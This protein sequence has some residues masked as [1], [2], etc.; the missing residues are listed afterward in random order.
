MCSFKRDLA[1]KMYI[2]IIIIIIMLAGHNAVDEMPLFWTRVQS[3]CLVLSQPEDGVRN[4]Q[5][6]LRAFAQ[7]QTAIAIYRLNS[8]IHYNSF[9]LFLVPAN[10]GIEVSCITR[11]SLSVAGLSRSPVSKSAQNCSL[12]S[13]VH[14]VVGVYTFMM[15]MKRLSLTRRQNFI[16]LSFKPMVRLGICLGACVHH[17]SHLISSRL[18][19]S[20]AGCSPPPMS[21]IFVCLLPS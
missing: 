10:S 12:I 3:R 11:T 14:G 7:Q 19:P 17:T 13:S 8:M 2:I 16:S 1:Q 18:C 21:S 5:F 6:V 20:T 9:P 4:R 15:A